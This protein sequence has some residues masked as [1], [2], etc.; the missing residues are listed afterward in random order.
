[1]LSHNTQAPPV[2]H[3]RV[4]LNKHCNLIAEDVSEHHLTLTT[5]C[6]RRCGLRLSEGERAKTTLTNLGFIE[7]FKVRTGVGRGKTGQAMR[8]T[9]AGWKW[10]GKRPKKS[11]KGGD[12]VNHEFFVQHLAR[13]I[14]HS[15]IETLGVDLVIAY[16][17]D[18]HTNLHRALETLS[19]RS[20][21]LNTGDLV[22]L[23]V[24]TSSPTVT[25]ARNVVKDAGSRSP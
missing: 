25:G 8:L 9:P 11:T 5:P 22:A 10:I 4:A 19:A 12:S 6:F 1:M 20:I 16:N 7:S 18:E 24:E 2:S 3:N 23:E 15:S 17:T 21:A 14:P 13:L